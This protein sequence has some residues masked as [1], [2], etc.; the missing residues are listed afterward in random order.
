MDSH[1]AIL[2]FGKS[3]IERI[4]NMYGL[5]ILMRKL[6]ALAISASRAILLRLAILNASK[7]DI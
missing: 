3:T 6:T 7:L 4:L 5:N 1:C 2:G